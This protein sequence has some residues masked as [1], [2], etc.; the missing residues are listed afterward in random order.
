MAACV[1]TIR[2]HWGGFIEGFSQ[3]LGC[4]SVLQAELHGTLRG[5]QLAK[6]KGLRKIVIEADSLIAI[7]LIDKGCLPSHIALCVVE[8]IRKIAKA[9]D[10]ISWAHIFKEANGLADCF[11]NY[12]LD[13][14][15]NFRTFKYVPDC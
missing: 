11:A 10:S 8:E 2:D 9:F 6:R 12:D 4:C 7:S 14:S 1:G 15:V 13:S 5:L 3:N